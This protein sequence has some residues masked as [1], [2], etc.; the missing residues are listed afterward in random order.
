MC[1]V[2]PLEAFFHFTIQHT[3][4]P[5]KFQAGD[6]C[7]VRSVLQKGV[8]LIQTMVQQRSG[9]QRH[10]VYKKIQPRRRLDFHGFGLLYYI[11]NWI[12]QKAA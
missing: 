5:V 4:F 11:V 10:I 1:R 2:R 9:A 7:R 12:A 3:V 8:G 6:F